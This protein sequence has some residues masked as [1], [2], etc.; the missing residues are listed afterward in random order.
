MAS[1]ATLARLSFVSC[2]RGLPNGNTV[3]TSHH[4]KDKEIKL[5]EVTPDKKIVWTH[6]D[7]KK[8]G[9]HHFQ[10]LD[11]NGKALDGKALK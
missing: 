11:T 7:D 10:I 9:I 2:L 5:F 6:V 8:F 3:I 1:S 4:A